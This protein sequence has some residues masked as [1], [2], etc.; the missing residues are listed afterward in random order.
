MD[1][2]FYKFHGA[3][4]DFIMIDARKLDSGYFNS[5]RVRLMCDRHFGIGADG[6]ILLSGSNSEGYRMIYFNSDGKE[7][8]M[9][10]NGGRCFAAFAGMLGLMDNKLEF[11][12][13]DGFHLAV[14]ETDQTFRLR[15][16]NVTEV[17]R[18]TDGYLVETGSRHL[19]IFRDNID[20]ID[21]FREGREIRYQQRFG[22]AGTNVNFVEERSDHSLRIRTYERGVENETLACGTGS[23]AAA[24]SAY[25]R[26]ITDKT[27]YDIQAPGGNLKVSFKPSE[28]AR[29]EEVWLQGPAEFVFQGKINV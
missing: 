22:T 14:K 4:N 3:G 21:V 16:M 25:M 29:F 24:I 20:S 1:V 6:L 2:E 11:S 17:S 28:N 13:I 9:C 5:E 8:T 27:S 7:G 15:M 26:G 18:L 23:V 19:V 12:G 10:G